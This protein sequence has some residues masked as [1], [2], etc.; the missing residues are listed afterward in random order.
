MSLLFANMSILTSMLALLAL[1]ATPSA[2]RQRRQ[3]ARERH[4]RWKAALMVAVALLLAVGLYLFG[5]PAWE[6][7]PHE[8]QK[9]VVQLTLPYRYQQDGYIFEVDAVDG[10]ATLD[11]AG[12][13]QFSMGQYTIREI[14]IVGEE[15]TD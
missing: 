12:Q 5:R 15:G 13:P 2:S 6:V 4:P 1:N 14:G 3:P 11:E 10:S 7:A 8:E 9:Q